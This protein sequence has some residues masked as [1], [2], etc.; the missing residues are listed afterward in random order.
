MKALC[1]AILALLITGCASK[2]CT[3]RNVTASYGLF[4]PRIGYS[5]CNPSNCC[6]VPTEEE[7]L[8]GCDKRCPCW[9]HSKHK[10]QSID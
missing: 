5:P 7:I 4:G 10:K 8:C 1:A 2:P 3:D 6:N 9:G